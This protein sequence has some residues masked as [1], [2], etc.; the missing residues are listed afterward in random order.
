[1]RSRCAQHARSTHARAHKHGC[2]RTRGWPAV[3]CTAARSCAQPPLR[4]RGA[5]RGCGSASAARTAEAPAS[6]AHRAARRL[7]LTHA[8]AHARAHARRPCQLAVSYLEIYN[9]QLSDL[10]GSLPGERPAHSADLQL[11]EDAKSAEISVKGQRVVRVATEEEALN[12]LFEGESNRAVA[13]HELNKHSTRG[14]AVFTVHAAVR[15]RVE[16]HG[17]VLSAKLNLVDLAGSERLKKTNTAGER[18]AESMAINRSLSYLEQ[19]VVA[20]AQKGRAHLPY[21][22][23]KLTHLL[24]DAIGGNC[25]TT[26]VAC[27]Y[28]EGAHLEETVSTLAFAARAMRVHNAPL[29]NETA[30]PATLLRRYKAEV[31]QLKHELAMH[32]A[33][34][35]R[36]R[37]AYDAYTDA[38]K[39]ELAQGLKRYLQVRGARARVVAR[40][41]RPRRGRPAPPPP[42]D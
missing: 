13:V 40:S 18:M 6:R 17:R 35:S 1:M 29:A 33:L 41:V 14:H 7:P 19:L 4:Q 12:L 27:V 15:S 26:L 10:L 24:K 9:D 25:K 30:D 31:A 3:R 34:A 20:L 28:A 8:R 21:R 36:S 11:C 32:D 16:S 37:V 38:Q 22:Q 5:A 2:A 42:R 23:S 39:A